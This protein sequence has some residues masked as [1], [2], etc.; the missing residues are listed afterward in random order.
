MLFFGDVDYSSDD[1]SLDYVDIWGHNNYIRYGYH[2]YFCY[3]DRISAKPLVMTEFG[4]DACGPGLQWENQHVQA[5]WVTHEWEQVRDNCIGGTIMEYCDEW[6]KCGSPS[7]H[8]LCGYYTCDIERFDRAPKPLG[9][10]CIVAR[11]KNTSP[12]EKGRMFS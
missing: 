5:E 4:V 11:Q 9:K 10:K 3:Y 2:S 8:D 12:A 7:T 6:W 1:A